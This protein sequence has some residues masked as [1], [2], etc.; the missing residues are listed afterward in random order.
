MHSYA[1]GF[2]VW[3]RDRWEPVGS[4]PDRLLG[5][6]CLE[7]DLI[8]GMRFPPDLAPGDRLLIT[9]TGSYDHSMA[10]NFARG[11]GRHRTLSD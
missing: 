6:T 2:F 5:R 9:D 3:R 11:G 10:F 7:Y 1:H 4:G 8:D